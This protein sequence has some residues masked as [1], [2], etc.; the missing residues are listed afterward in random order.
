[1]FWRQDLNGEPKARYIAA[2]VRAAEEDQMRAIIRPVAAALSIAC[3]TLLTVPVTIGSALAQDKQS[4]PSQETSKQ[5]ALTDKQIESVFAA[6]P[7]IDAIVNKQPQGAGQPNP[8][9]IA[10]LDGVARK[11]GFA[12]FAEYDDITANISLV[13]E[14]FDPQTKKYVGQDVVLKQEIAAVQADKKMPAND[15]KKMLNQLNEELKS[16]TPLQFPGNVD[17]VAKYY[18][19]LSE[20]MSGNQ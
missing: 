6:K 20:A 8:K 3:L 11:H 19:K 14:G 10:Q 5:I 2:L 13:M 4:D 7:D 1:M 17:V 9:V 16:V 15:K 18:D 12:N